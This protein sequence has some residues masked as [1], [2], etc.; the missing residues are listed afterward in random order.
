M[1]RW[2]W[3]GWG[4]ESDLVR[5][6]QW[7]LWR[8]G[9]V[10][11][12]ACCSCIWLVVLTARL[13]G[14]THLR[15]H[16]VA[17]C[18]GCCVSTGQRCQLLHPV[19]LLLRH[20]PLLVHNLL[21]PS[22]L[23]R[24]AAIQPCTTQPACC[25]TPNQVPY[26]TSCRVLQLLSCSLWLLQLRPLTLPLQPLL[27]SLTPRA[28][29]AAWVQV[30]CAAGGSA[31][32]TAGCQPPCLPRHSCGG[33]SPSTTWVHAADTGNLVHAAGCCCWCQTRASSCRHAELGCV[34]PQGACAQ[35]HG[36]SQQQGGTHFWSDS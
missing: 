36:L 14:V 10:A 13:A 15:P 18:P 11:D 3:S 17:N 8:R 31:R 34:V 27:L 12:A 23:S 2:Q 5:L 9:G 7:S 24:T 32:H 20:S 33:C 4:G 29:A 6:P 1:G 19:G 16:E 22:P 21:S 35:L 30:W 26:G 25:N 28:Q